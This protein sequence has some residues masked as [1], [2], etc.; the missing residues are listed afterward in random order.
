MQTVRNLR[1]THEDVGGGVQIG[2]VKQ[3][4]FQHSFDVQPAE[5]GFYEM[6]YRGYDFGPISRFG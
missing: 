2:Y 6:R 4:G 3:F 5:H 1:E